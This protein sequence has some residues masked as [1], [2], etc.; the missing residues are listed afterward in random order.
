MSRLTHIWRL[1]FLFL[2]FSFLDGCKG[3]QKSYMLSPLVRARNVIPTPNKEPETSTQV[4]PYPPQR[5]V[6]PEEPSNL[7]SL[8]TIRTP[9]HTPAP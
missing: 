9:D 6:I 7:I 3:Q 2:A 1:G 5:P 8:P 4:E